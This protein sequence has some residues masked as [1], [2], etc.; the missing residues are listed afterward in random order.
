MKGLPAPPSQQNK[1][2]L[3]SLLSS[4]TVFLFLTVFPFI[5][6]NQSNKKFTFSYLYFRFL[7]GQE[8][9]LHTH[10]SCHSHKGCDRNY[11]KLLPGVQKHH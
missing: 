5:S 9:L 10:I 8:Q 4:T 1:K 6:S 3:H 7:R 2:P 11:H